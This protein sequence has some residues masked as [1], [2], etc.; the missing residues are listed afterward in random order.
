MFKKEVTNTS[1]GVHAENTRRC[2]YA[3]CKHTHTASDPEVW[4]Q[5]TPHTLPLPP[6]G[7]EIKHP[8]P[9]REAL[10]M[11][12][13]SPGGRPGAAERGW[14]DSDRSHGGEGDPRRQRRDTDRHRRCPE[15]P[16]S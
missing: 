15:S 11:T 3:G 16:P 5:L 1:P 10:P 14:A 9:G 2:T 4:G 7:P 12:Q 8:G 6:H 13:A